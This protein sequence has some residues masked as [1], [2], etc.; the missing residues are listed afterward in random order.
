ME[1]PLPLPQECSST[2]RIR[3][4]IV[5]DLYMRGVL[6]LDDLARVAELPISIFERELSD[7][8]RALAGGPAGTD[9]QPTGTLLLSVVIPVYNERE[10]FLKLLDAV[11]PCRSKRDPHHRRLLDGRNARNA[12]GA[13]GRA[14]AG[15]PDPLSAGEQG[16]GAALRRGF[17]AGRGR[18][19]CIVQDADLEYDPGEYP[20]LIEPILEGRRTWSSARGSSASSHRVL[21]FWHSVGNRCSPAFQHVH[22]PEPHRHGD[23][24]QGLP[25]R[26]DPGDPAQVEPLR[27]RAGG[28]GE[29]RAARPELARSTRC[30]SATPAAPTK[31]ARRSAGRTASRRSGVSCDTPSGTDRESVVRNAQD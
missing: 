10:T 2:E 23:L 28:D 12:P 3:F 1:L 20:K 30:R 8:F 29:D 31:K 4:A 15:G 27:V 7:R 24:L 19:S 18:R 17:D 14:G 5:A 26:G 25:P 9:A 21:Y 11:R 6:N 16:K 22:Q 13:R